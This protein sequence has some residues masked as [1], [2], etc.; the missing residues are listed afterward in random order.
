MATVFIIRYALFWSFF[1]QMPIARIKKCV[2]KNGR[3]AMF[4]NAFMYGVKHLHYEEHRTISYLLM[5][6]ETLNRGHISAFKIL[7]RIYCYNAILSGATAFTSSYIGNLRLWSVH[8][9]D[10]CWPC[11][12]NHDKNSV[13]VLRLF[14]LAL[15]F[16]IRIF[17]CWRLWST[18]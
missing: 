15:V 5:D 6:H 8:T 7:F 1:K 18:K 2:M 17:Y 10:I 14:F 4:A 16:R 3:Q 9:G 11:S 13:G 12:G